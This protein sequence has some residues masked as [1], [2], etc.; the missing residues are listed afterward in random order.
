MGCARLVYNMVVANYVRNRRATAQFFFRT[1]L[2]HKIR[3]T[4]EWAFMAKVPYE[5]LDH[6]ISGAIS[7]RDEV[8]TRNR[9]RAQTGEGSHNRLTF[10]RKKDTRN[11]ITIRA[12]YCRSDL[13]FYLRLLHNKDIVAADDVEGRK[14]DAYD[15]PK[16]FRP[17]LHHERM[18][19]NHK[20]P[21]EGGEVTMDSS[22][23]YDKRLR[24][25]TFNWVYGKDVKDSENQAEPIIAAIDP[26]VVTFATWYSPT[27][28]TGTVGTRDI[29]RVIRLC[30]SLDLLIGKTE[31]VHAR[32]RNA[33]RRAQARVRLKIRN[34]VDEMHKKVALWAVRTFD[35]IV[36]PIFGAT[37]MSL[38]RPGRRL[39][40]KTVRKMLT[41]SHAR[42]R[43]RLLCKAEEHGKTI[44]TS[45]SEAYTSKTCTSCGHIH[46]RLGGARV[47]RCSSCGVVMDRD[48][49]AAKGI[50]LRAL[51]S[52]A[53][54][55]PET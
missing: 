6:A 29:E 55:A 9:E 30:L 40:R 32:K 20:W 11:T 36:L 54:S 35:I 45:V 43:K 24:Q 50:L 12:Q 17:P 13:R 28:G 25:W 44:I 46:T 2:K 49:N 26:G 33:H 4:R 27:L 3:T 48:A 21:N 16:L 52:G 41:W 18:K 31:K 14:K 22:L 34:L 1:L 7:A 47:F 42:F 15:I 38:R 23:T 39:N 51:A 8:I 19:T 10:R 53:L 37:C 5:V